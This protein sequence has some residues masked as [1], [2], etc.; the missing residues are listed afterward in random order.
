ML[1][2]LS[3]QSFKLFKKKCLCIQEC[4]WEINQRTDV[5]VALELGEMVELLFLKA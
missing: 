4:S 5:T 2:T 1:N 3:W